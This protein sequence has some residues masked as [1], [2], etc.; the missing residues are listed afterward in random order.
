MAIFHLSAKVISRS[1][2]RSSVGAA[3]YRS[4]ERL[5]NRQSGAVHDFGRKQGID[6]SA[7]LL[8][9]A[10]PEWIGNRQELWNAVENSET[11]VNS[12]T[13]RELVLALPVELSQREQVELLRGFALEQFVNRGMVADLNL[14]DAA[15]HNPHAHL[16]LTTREI[17][18]SGFGAKVRAWDKVELLQEW[19]VPS[20]MLVLP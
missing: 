19:R 8:P 6:F 11:R 2:G 5:V 7:V 3:A 14:H 9:S 20:V 12:R 10:A 15:S 4:G 18:S 13:A 1:S 17:T 16:M